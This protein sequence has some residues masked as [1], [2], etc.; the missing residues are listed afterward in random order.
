MKSVNNEFFKGVVVALDVVSI[1]DYGVCFKEIVES[2]G[3]ERVLKEIRKN[4]LSK[5]KEMAKREFKD[6]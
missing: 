4:G 1:Y 2:A 6:A 3:K 5:T